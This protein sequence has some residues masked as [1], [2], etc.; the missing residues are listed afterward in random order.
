M[1]Q[2]I[3][4]QGSVGS[5]DPKEYRAK[6]RFKGTIQGYGADA[7]LVGITTTKTCLRLDYAPFSTRKIVF[8][9]YEEYE[10][11]Y[12]YVHGGSWAIRIAFDDVGDELIGT[13][14]VY[15]WEANPAKAR[16]V[17][18]S[19]EGTLDADGIGNFKLVPVE[20]DA[21]MGTLKLRALVIPGNGPTPPKITEVLEVSGK[22][23]GQ[24][25]A[26]VF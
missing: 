4:S 17:E 23:L 5:D 18:T 22:I 21:P 11:T 8:C 19:V 24:K 7:K 9:H 15:L 1:E 12:P 13:A 3:K 14:F 25:F 10:Q 20:D 6:S 2:I 26:E 16:I